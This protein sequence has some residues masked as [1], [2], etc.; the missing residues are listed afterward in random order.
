MMVKVMLKMIVHNN[1]EEDDDEVPLGLQDL[2][3]SRDINLHLHKGIKN[4]MKK[5]FELEILQICYYN[6]IDQ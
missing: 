6:T 2:Q 3:V 5:K 1:E 4:F